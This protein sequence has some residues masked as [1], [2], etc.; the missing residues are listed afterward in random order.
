MK[1]SIEI[2]TISIIDNIR[3]IK[4]IIC[5]TRRLRVVWSGGVAWDCDGNVEEVDM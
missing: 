4:F 2:H 5:M 1:V 3:T